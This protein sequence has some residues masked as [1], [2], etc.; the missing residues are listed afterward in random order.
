MKRW[1]NICAGLGADSVPLT[2]EVLRQRAEEIAASLG[3]TGVF[4]S[5][6]FARR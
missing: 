6:G 4:G 5:A 3:V 2:M 1:Y